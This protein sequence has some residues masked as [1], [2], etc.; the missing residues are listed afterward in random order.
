MLPWTLLVVGSAASLP[1]TWA[2]TSLRGPRGVA[3]SVDHVWG[4]QQS[5]QAYANDSGGQWWVRARTPI[6]GAGY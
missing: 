2:W 5:H 4:W 3:R 6:A 1:Q